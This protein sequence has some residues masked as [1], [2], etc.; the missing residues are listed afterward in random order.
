MAIFCAAINPYLR[1][2][3]WGSGNSQ[4]LETTNGK[5]HSKILCKYR[6]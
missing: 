2:G 6:K 1:A 4:G 5:V 3:I